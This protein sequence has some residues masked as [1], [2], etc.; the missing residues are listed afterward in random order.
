MSNFI[1]KQL[2]YYRKTD[3]SEFP[4]ASVDIVGTLTGARTGSYTLTF[5]RLSSDHC[6]VRFP[7]LLA[8][9]AVATGPITWTPTTTSE[10]NPFLPTGTTQ[11]LLKVTSNTN[12]NVGL[13]SILT[14]G[15]V[16]IYSDVDEGDFTSGQNAGVSRSTLGYTSKV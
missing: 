13:A 2:K 16:N 4:T 1:T 7:F 15:T 10:L 9:S 11:L 12:V 8:S 3:N 14:S 5:Q 6:I